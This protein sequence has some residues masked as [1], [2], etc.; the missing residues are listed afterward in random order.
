MEEGKVNATTIIRSIMS[1]IETTY[2]NLG[3]LS[4]RLHSI[5]ENHTDNMYVIKY[6]FIPREK[7]TKR[8]YYRAKINI[9]TRA[10]S[11]IQEIKEEDLAKDDS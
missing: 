9:T 7:D 6:S 10:L 8:I 5:K 2:G 11:E 4:F 1:T 3:F